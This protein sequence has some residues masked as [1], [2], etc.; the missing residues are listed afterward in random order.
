M[1]AIERQRELP[2]DGFADL[3][4]R[5]LQARIA[6]PRQQRFD[7]DSGILKIRSGTALEFRKAADIKYI[8]RFAVVLQIGKFQ[9]A[10]TDRFGDLFPFLFAELGPHARFADSLLRLR[11]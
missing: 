11:D 9:S 3:D 6:G 8:I 4:R 10:E 1:E 5:E 2:L 7:A